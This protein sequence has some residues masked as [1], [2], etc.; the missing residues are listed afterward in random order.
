M[1][2]QGPAAAFEDGDD[3]TVPSTPTLNIPARGDGFAEAVHS[4]QV[5]SNQGF[6]LPG[7]DFDL[8]AGTQSQL[9]AQEGTRRNLLEL[10][11]PQKIS[12]IVLF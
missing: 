3:C 12:T 2:F 6:D 1:T 5:P 10:E 7:H 8:N 4:P 9:E 11:N